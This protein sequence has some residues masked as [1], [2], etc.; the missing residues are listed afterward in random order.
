MKTSKNQQRNKKQP[1]HKVNNLKIFLVKHASAILGILLRIKYRNKRNWVE[2]E[3]FDI[4]FSVFSIASAKILFIDGRLNTKIFIHPVVRFF[5][6]FLIKLLSHYTSREAA[7][8][9]NIREISS[10]ASLLI[11]KVIFTIHHVLFD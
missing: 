7:H 5:E 8:T 10:L 2:P 11:R 3:N 9:K 4:C 1:G 6:K